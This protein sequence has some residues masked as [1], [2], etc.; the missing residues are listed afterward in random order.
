MRT[1]S[2]DFDGSF[3]L[4]E[5]EIWPDGDAPKDWTAKDVVKVMKRGWLHDWNCES[6]LTTIVT[7]D[8]TQEET[9]VI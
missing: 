6:D 9:K 7:A 8:A 1:A 4:D 5:S 3:T 2:F